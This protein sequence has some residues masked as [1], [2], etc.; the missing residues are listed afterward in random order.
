MR[1]SF[2]I[3]LARDLASF[4]SVRYN[5]H[6]E[7]SAALEIKQATQLS[8]LLNETAPLTYDEQLV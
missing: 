1:F 5:S 8:E 7:Q 2:R 4:C 3:A 6:R